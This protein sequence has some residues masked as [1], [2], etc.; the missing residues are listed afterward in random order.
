MSA[1]RSM[2]ARDARDLRILE[3]YAVHG[4]SAREIA[5]RVG[6]TRNALQGLLHRIQTDDAAASR[7]SIKP[8]YL[9]GASTLNGDW[10]WSSHGSAR[11]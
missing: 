3:M 6:M 11:R 9:R 8:A 4:L 2:D 7:T 1:T 10:H 5:P